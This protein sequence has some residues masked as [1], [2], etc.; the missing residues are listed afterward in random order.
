MAG[1]WRSLRRRL[2]TPS[3]SQTTVETRGFHVK[4]D[5]SRALLETVGRQFLAGFAHA[6]EASEPAMAEA[7]LEAI[8]WPFRGFAYE[9]ATMGFALLDGLAVG[10]HDRVQRFIAGRGGDHIYMAYVGV[11]W[12]MARLPRFRWSVVSPTDPLLRW[13]VL[14]GYG[15]HQAFFKTQKYVH[16]HFQEPVFP[17]PADGYGEYANR[18]VDQGIGRAMWFVAGT[19]VTQLSTMISRFDPR[20]H[21]DLWS[22]AGLAATY[23]GGADEKELERFLSLAG[24]HRAMASQASAFAVQARV[25]AGLV[26]EHTK[27]AAAVFC[28][29]TPEEAGAVTDEAM[30]G[31]PPDGTVPAYEVWRQRIARAFVSV[32]KH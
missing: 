8:D 1:G 13:L 15:F 29:M 4:N 24:R 3:T 5:V 7:P 9:G 6:V 23:A 26:T 28:G 21:E 2:L 30:V 20:R 11:G 10:R 17:W 25:K 14:D 18:V 31:L 32:K 16:G 27:L 22:G 12:A 19:D